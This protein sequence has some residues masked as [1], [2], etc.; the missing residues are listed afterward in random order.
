[1]RSGGIG[2][3]GPI[4]IDPTPEDIGVF[5]TT[6]EENALFVSAAKIPMHMVSGDHMEFA[7]E[8]NIFAKFG[9]RKGELRPCHVN[10][11]A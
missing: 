4:G 1:M 2:V 3:T 7:R 9:I 10:E 6:T 11:V 5:D 8:L